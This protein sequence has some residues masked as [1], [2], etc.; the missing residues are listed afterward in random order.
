M[1]LTK[2]T[3]IVALALTAALLGGSIG[4]VV[5]HSESDKMNS[6]ASASSGQPL[7][8]QASDNNGLSS[9]DD[10][11]SNVPAENTESANSTESIQPE[12]TSNVVTSTKIN[13]AR[14]VESVRATTSSRYAG[15]TAS[16]SV[17]R[18]HEPSRPVSGWEKHR[19]I[20]T[21]ALGTGGGALLGGLIGGRKGTAIGAI[22]GA[23]SSAL[24]T[25][26]LRKR[27]PRY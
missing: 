20:L 10:T 17:Y 5:E 24:Y 26:K 19:D 8:T 1:T 7:S 21:V 2:N 13:R 18:S 23:G 6:V 4:A 15:H 11:L 14:R 22:A 9:G 16:R 25:L 3:K 12:N 27:K